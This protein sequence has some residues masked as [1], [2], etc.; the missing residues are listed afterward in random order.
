MKL[1]YRIDLD[2]HGIWRPQH[3]AMADDMAGIRRNLEEMSGN[4][5]FITQYAIITENDLT[6]LEDRILPSK[7]FF[8]PA[9]NMHFDGMVNVPTESGERNVPFAVVNAPCYTTGYEDRETRRHPTELLRCMEHLRLRWQQGYGL[10]DSA[11]GH[12][13]AI[14]AGPYGFPGQSEWHK[15]LKQGTDAWQEEQR[16][17][18]LMLQDMSNVRGRTYY[19]KYHPFWAIELCQ[20]IV[21]KRATGQAL[22]WREQLGGAFTAGAL[23]TTLPWTPDSPAVM[24]RV[25]QFCTEND[26]DHSGDG[27]SLVIYMDGRRHTVNARFNTRHEVSIYTAPLDLQHVMG[28][29]RKGRTVKLSLEQLGRLFDKQA[30]IDRKTMTECIRSLVKYGA[31]LSVDPQNIEKVEEL[32]HE[33]HMMVGYWGLDNALDTDLEEQFLRVYDQAVVLGSEGLEGLAV[34]EE[35]KAA[36]LKGLC[37]HVQEYMLAQGA[38]Y[39]PEMRQTRKIMLEAAALWNI[40][41][42]QVKPYDNQVLTFIRQLLQ[43]P[44]P[45]QQAASQAHEPAGPPEGENAHQGPSMD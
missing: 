6:L 11:I 18:L 12:C 41:T 1:Q 32:R 37:R 44:T 23:L 13:Q 17:G 10:S 39:L 5:R 15:V 22:G 30:P 2:D 4:T 36:L 31:A 35:D 28:S 21:A 3:R 9:Y 19:R 40:P 29:S 42:E 7:P 24:D 26:I 33:L 25:R 34:T 8:H 43:E 45:D 38:E 27:D 20:R 16:Q 14:V